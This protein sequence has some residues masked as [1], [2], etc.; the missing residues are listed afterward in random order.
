MWWLNQYPSQQYF[1]RE[2]EGSVTKSIR[3]SVL[4]NVPIVVPSPGK[5]Y[6]IIQLANTLAREQQA[7]AQLRR[8]GEHLMNTI[9]NDLL[10]NK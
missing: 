7:L 2:A 1:Q 10:N 6:A 5:Q 4:E 8:S 3:R 9:A